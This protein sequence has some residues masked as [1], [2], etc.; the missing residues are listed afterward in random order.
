MENKWEKKCC[1]CCKHYNW[2]YDICNRGLIHANVR[3][4]CAA[5]EPDD[6]I[7]EILDKIHE[8]V[9]EVVEE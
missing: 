5:F 8:V 6:D 1:D 3:Q 2:E 7:I 9:R 4:F